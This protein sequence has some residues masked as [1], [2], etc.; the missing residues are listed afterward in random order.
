MPAGAPPKYSEPETLQAKVN[1]YFDH[2]DSGRQVEELTKRGD[3]VAYNKRRP[4]TVEGLSNWL[5]IT[6][7]TLNEYGK[8]PKFSDIISRARAKIKQQ[9][10]EMGLDN[11]YNAKMAALCLA[12]HDPQYRINQDN[13]LN[14][15]LSIED[16]LRQVSE[17][18]N[19][20][21][22]HSPQGI[23]DLDK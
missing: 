16:V 15:R 14:V 23:I 12:A 2:C 9:W 5:D 20:A 4:Y 22:H 17:H 7:E 6:R 18:R 21:I 11:T 8:T 13:T 10:I 1:E 3:V 19:P